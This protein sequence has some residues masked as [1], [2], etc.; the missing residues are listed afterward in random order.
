M[1]ELL[2]WMMGQSKKPLKGV[3]H[4]GANTGQEAP[5]YAALGLKAIWVEAD[6]QLY[7]TLTANVARF[8]G[9]TAYQCLASDI[10]GLDADFHI[11]SNGGG[12]SSILKPDE[13]RF[14]KEWP[15][16]KEL[17]CVRLR[18][19]RLDSLFTAQ[20]CVLDN[21]NALVADV[22]GHE[23]S[24]FR[25]LGTLLNRFEAVLSEINW[26]PMYED[27]TKPY[28]LE[29]FLVG[30]GFKRA[31]LGVSWPQA[32][33]VWIRGGAGPFERLYMA[34]SA[35]L[36]FVAARCGIVKRLRASGIL[37]LGRGLYCAAKRRPA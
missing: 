2:Q 21:I 13:Y 15:G 11:A 9:Q 32:T 4:I 14:S 35:R 18:T 31:W 30:R 10:D 17:G 25:G 29:D 37:G 26:A 19:C 27:S 7:Q 28:E 24:V 1:S 6:P 36:Y 23:L 20:H 12:S 33:G 16:V 34:G 5:C 22:Q 3:L 8:P